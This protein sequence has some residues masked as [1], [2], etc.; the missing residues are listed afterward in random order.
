VDIHARKQVAEF[1]ELL[2]PFLGAWQSLEVRTGSVA[3]EST[4]FCLIFAGTLE[5]HPPDQLPS[6]P[7]S[8]STNLFKAD[9]K[10]FP[11]SHLDTLINNL[12]TDHLQLDERQLR[13]GKAK[14]DG[15]AREGL[16]PNHHFERAGETRWGRNE[17]AQASIV[18]FSG[19]TSLHDASGGLLN[20]HDLDLQLRSLKTPYHDVDD[21]LQAFYRQPGAK[22][23]NT[24]KAFFSLRAP[25]PVTLSQTLIK[26][27]YLQGTIVLEGGL[28]PDKVE[29]G[30][31]LI[32]R[33]GPTR[34][35]PFVLTS[36]HWARE[37]NRQIA[38]FK[39]DMKEILSCR[40]YL[41]YAGIHLVAREFENPEAPTANVAI[42]A[43]R[44]FDEGMSLFTKWLAG[45]GKDPGDDLEKAVGWLFNF[46][47]FRTNGYGGGQ[48]LDNEVDQ[49]CMWEEGK[50]LL[51][52]E[53]T[54]K[55]TNLIQKMKNVFR[56]CEN[57]KH[58]LPGW[59]I[60][61][62]VATSMARSEL[63]ETER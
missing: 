50:T 14:S 46:L 35:E 5:V 62:I 24:S 40:L 42:I 37:E 41:G 51:G 49:V 28:S 34:R 18:L 48:D 10:A 43:H 36:S 25:I 30:M 39:M 56:R 63:T 6:A 12:F 3:V 58:L 8:P 2:K 47:G 57:L 26:D 60:V 11:I 53:C 38:T 45:K 33:K 4:E 22:F 7:A 27:N 20:D 21:M 59:D 13:F 16:S 1:L 29:L 9:R 15:T 61:P 55:S 19:G 52:I 17:L 54:T 31:I 32:P 44:H 23:G